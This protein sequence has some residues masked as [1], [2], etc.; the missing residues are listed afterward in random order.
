MMVELWG[1]IGFLVFTFSTLVFTILYLTMSRWYKSF[2][3]T[4]IAIF[5]VSVVILS[6]YIA[7]R[8]WGFN[9]PGVE[10][11]RLVIFWVLGITMLTSVIGFLEV[12]FGRRGER[13]RARLSK[14]Y[15]DVKK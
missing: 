3:G 14:R 7:V 6:A 9:P 15:D 5:S 4:I 13:L 12:Q 8:V 2:V 11:L 10:W 1:D